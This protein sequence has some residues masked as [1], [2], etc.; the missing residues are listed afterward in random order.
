MGPRQEQQ[1]GRLRLKKYRFVSLKYAPHCCVEK[2]VQE[3]GVGDGEEATVETKAN[4]GW[5]GKV[6]AVQLEGAI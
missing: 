1:A 2:T 3:H 4:V 5:I 6:M